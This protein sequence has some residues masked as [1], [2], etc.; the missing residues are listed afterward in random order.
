MPRRK[1]EMEAVETSQVLLAILALTVADRED[2]AVD[3]TP[4]RRTEV[5]LAELGL[6]L[7]VIAR[8][9]GKNYEAVKASVR[10]AREK[11]ATGAPA[12]ADREP[13]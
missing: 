2:R 13:V 1:D 10:R 6:P 8:L 4:S 3:R 9:T 12:A 11:A 5:V 7:T